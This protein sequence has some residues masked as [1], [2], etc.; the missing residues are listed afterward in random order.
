MEVILL[1]E[2][3]RVGA[4]RVEPEVDDPDRRPVSG[5]RFELLLEDRRKG[6]V[7]DDPV[8]ERRAA[9]DDDEAMLAGHFLPHPRPSIPP[10]IHA[11]VL[12]GAAMVVDIGRQQRRQRHQH[13]HEHG[14]QR[15][16]DPLSRRGQFRRPI[17]ELR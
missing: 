13:R 14:H 11:G 4:L 15:K 10:H 2:L 1:G 8:P 3:E 16:N 7:P 12:L 5:Q 17:S 9:A 6:L